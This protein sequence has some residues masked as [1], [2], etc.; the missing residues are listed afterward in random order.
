MMASSSRRTA[1]WAASSSVW[2]PTAS[3]PSFCAIGGPA[4]HVTYLS[5]GLAQRG[6][7][8]TL[9][10]LRAV[11]ELAVSRED[12]GPEFREFLIDYVKGL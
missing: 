5:R 10:Y 4:L 12:L 6:Y 1:P 9:E 7:D 3:R 8:T 2:M 11:V